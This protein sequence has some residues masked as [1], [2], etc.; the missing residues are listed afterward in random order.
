MKNLIFGEVTSVTLK[1]I[2]LIRNIG[3]K[4][5]LFQNHNAISQI[6]YIL[7]KGKT[8]SRRFLAEALVETCGKKGSIIVYNDNFEKTRNR[9]L[10]ELFTDLSESLLEI[11]S[12]IIDLLIPFRQRALYSP[13]QHS[14]ASIKYVLPA[15]CD[16]SYTGMEIANGSQAMDRYLAFLTGT[17]SDEEEKIL[18]K[19]LEDYC[20][21]DTYAMVKLID[22]LYEKVK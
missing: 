11:N 16:L 10:A 9:E 14:S 18:F 4:R 22:V 3:K 1:T 17:L 2:R 21:Q 13:K 12:R 15:F 6:R 7:I 19:G 8:D 20:Y 5:L